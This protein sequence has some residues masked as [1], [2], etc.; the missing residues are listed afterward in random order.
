M[1]CRTCRIAHVEEGC[2]GVI[3]DKPFISRACSAQNIARRRSGNTR[4][5]RGDFVETTAASETLRQ[6]GEKSP[7][8]T[9]L[10]RK[11]AESGA[12]ANLVHLVQQIDDIEAHL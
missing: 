3:H 12:A 8:R 6:P 9:E 4:Q 2:A 7:P 5:D 11:D 10:R 1:R